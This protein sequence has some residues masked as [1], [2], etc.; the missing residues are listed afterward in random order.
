MLLRY[1]CE[2]FRSISEYQEILLTAEQ[3][4]DDSESSLITNEGFRGQ[5]LPIIEIYGG[6]GSGKTNLLLILRY[7]V[8]K[9]LNSAHG[10]TDK[11]FVPKFKLDKECKTKASTFDIDF[12]CNE[13]HYYYGFSIKDN[14]VIEEWLYQIS[15][16]LRKSTTTLFYRDIDAEEEFT[17]GKALKGNNKNIASVTGKGCLF[18]SMAAKSEHQLLSEIFKYFEESYEFRFSVELNERNIGESMFKHNVKSQISK[19]LSLVD[20]GA[21]EV[22][23]KEKEFDEKQITIFKS[24]SG[25][26]NDVFKA[27]GNESNMN[28]ES[29]SEMMEDAKEYQITVFR[30]DSEGNRVPFSFTQESLGTRAL[31]SFLASAF[32]VLRNGGVF[33]V[34][35][36]ESSLHTLL[37]LKIVELFSNKKSNPNNAQ[38][39]FSTH[40]TQLMNFE[41]VRRD[42][43]WLAEKC[44]NGSTK[45]ASLLEYSIDK[46][47]NWRKGYIEG[48]FGAIP[49]LGYVDEFNLFGDHDASKEA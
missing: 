32:Q 11:I 37:T 34:D 3:D 27:L 38:L 45:V 19:F 18:L 41:G 25:M 42:E 2:N 5:L 9:I 15:Y 36:V 10:D 16:G 23:V 40:E 7:I 26:M 35:E 24:I 29:F 28:P 8:S 1:G 43:I 49:I 13:K 4:Q 14:I 46:R 44:Q 17:F 31:I 33:I 30:N 48:R 20:V 47:S 21:V 12:I 22:D 39:V 6:N